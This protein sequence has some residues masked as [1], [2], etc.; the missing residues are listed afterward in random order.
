MLVPPYGGMVRSKVVKMF[1]RAINSF[2]T[3]GWPLF[4]QGNRY[5]C[6]DKYTLEDGE[7]NLKLACKAKDTILIEGR[8]TLVKDFGL[9]CS[10]AD[11]ISYSNSILFLSMVVSGFV[12]PLISD[13]RGRKIALLLGF[14]ISGVSIFA[15]GFASNFFFWQVCIAVAGFGISGVEIVSLVYVSEISA[16]R[17]RNHAMVALTTIWAVSQVFLGVIFTLVNNW[18]YIFTLVMGSPYLISLVISVFVF[19]ETPRY[20]LSIANFEVSRLFHYGR[21]RRRS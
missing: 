8:E 10:K 7:C 9:I 12:F 16:S 14:F 19:Y 1:P 13:Y 17:Y 4:F 18:R 2:L 5:R 11:T 15:A 20:Y 21:K 6:S 3:M